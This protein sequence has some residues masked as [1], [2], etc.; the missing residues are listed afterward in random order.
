MC[1]KTCYAHIQFKYSHKQSFESLDIIM[2]TLVQRKNKINNVI[3]FFKIGKG[4]ETEAKN[5]DRLITKIK[6]SINENN[7]NNS[8]IHH[9]K[10]CGINAPNQTPCC[11]LF[12]RK[13]AGTDKQMMA[14]IVWSECFSVSNLHGKHSWNKN[15]QQTCTRTFGFGKHRRAQRR[16]FG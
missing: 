11:Y 14:E 8:S 6:P 16:T 2:Y 13:M 1:Q 12:C 7:I 15:K 5:K 9:N 10:K 4:G 3:F